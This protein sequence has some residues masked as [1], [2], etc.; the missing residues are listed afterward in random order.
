MPFD[1]RRD[2]RRIL[3]GVGRDDG[4]RL[5]HARGGPPGD[6]FVPLLGSV[7]SGGVAYAGTRALGRS[8]VRYFFHGELRNRRS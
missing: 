2:G 3:G 7:V 6:K 8:A 5:R 1:E 4:G